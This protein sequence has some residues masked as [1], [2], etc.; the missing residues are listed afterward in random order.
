MQDVLSHEYLISY[1]DNFVFSVLIEN[2]NIVDVGA[3]AHKLVFLQSRTDESFLAVDVEFLVGLYHFG[4]LDGVEVLDFCEAWVLC[5]ILVFDV[6]EPVGCHL[7]HVVQVAVDACNLVV[8]AGNE[9]VGFVFVEFQD[10]LHLD[11]QQSQ[12][13][14]FSHLAHHLRIV[15]RQSLVDMLTNSI[16]VGRLFE[17]LVL[18]NALLDEDFLQ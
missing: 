16:H 12:N 11:F 1:A 3:V 15:G 9:L 6:L 8:D 5:T 10:A 2:D 7:H 13:I 4:S 18:I 17:F 14:I